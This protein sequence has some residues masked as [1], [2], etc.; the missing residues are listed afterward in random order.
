MDIS[1]KFFD[2][3]LKLEPFKDLLRELD[4]SDEDMPDL[5]DTFDV[6]ANGSLSILEL[7][8]GIRL[9][10]GDPRRS[11]VIGV[12]LVVQD[13]RSLVDKNEKEILSKVSE[14]LEQMRL[15]YKR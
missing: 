5:F 12:S 3:L 1:K 6:D 15:I 7:L 14:E 11:D 9:F 2:E 4:I 8:K 13:I 10:R